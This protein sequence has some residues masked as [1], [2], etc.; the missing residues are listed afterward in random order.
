LHPFVFYAYC[1]T[2]GTANTNIETITT[3]ENSENST[4]AKYEDIGD[5]IK[6]YS[7]V[8]HLSFSN[9]FAITRI[10]NNSV[11]AN[12]TLDKLFLT[13]GEWP[14]LERKYSLNERKSIY[15]T[16]GFNDYQFIK[17]WRLR[18]VQFIS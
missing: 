8:F 13:T 7:P 5:T 6:E 11:P 2:T 12:T 9:P 3:P 15:G 1:G 17:F 18:L 10:V 14:E 16:G 4:R